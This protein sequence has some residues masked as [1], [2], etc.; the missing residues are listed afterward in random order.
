ML[1]LLVC[2]Q[3]VCLCDIAR[4]ACTCRHQLRS[5]SAQLK[6]CFC[7]SG[8]VS[9]ASAEPDTPCQGTSLHFSPRYLAASLLAL[10]AF[11]GT[12][13]MGCTMPRAS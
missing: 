6:G 8:M 5:G 7:L 4:Q 12:H 13:V 11:S 1:R 3:A 2:M 10:G 9:G